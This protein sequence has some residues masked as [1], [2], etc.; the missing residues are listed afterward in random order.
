MR[1]RSQGMVNLSQE[2]SLH[3]IEVEACTLYLSTV[4]ARGW[5]LNLLGESA[6]AGLLANLFKCCYDLNGERYVWWTWDK[7][8][9]S[10]MLH[11][12]KRL[13]GVASCHALFS[14]WLSRKNF[15]TINSIRR[16]LPMLE[17]HQGYV[18]K[19]LASTLDGFHETL[20][21]ISNPFLSGAVVASLSFVSLPVLVCFIRNRSYKLFMLMGLVQ[22]L[23][24]SRTGVKKLDN[25]GLVRALIVY[26]AVQICC[27]IIGNAKQ[28]FST[29]K[30]EPFSPANP[31]NARYEIVGAKQ[32]A[33][34]H[35]LL[36]YQEALVQLQSFIERNTDNLEEVKK[37]NTEAIELSLKAMERLESSIR[38]HPST[39]RR[40]VYEQVVT[41]TEERVDLLNEQ[42]KTK[43]RHA[44]TVTEHL[45]AKEQSICKNIAGLERSIRELE[46]DPSGKP[47]VAAHPFGP[48]RSWY[49][50]KGSLDTPLAEKI[51]V[52]GVALVGIC[53]FAK[54]MI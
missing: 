50:V 44:K 14:G 34:E 21:N 38:E 47:V 18:L 5:G 45:K 49:T 28:H 37:T 11:L 29:S 33:L 32:V 7:R 19:T 35:K 39:G 54:S 31:T 20:S 22:A 23:R 42:I 27:S 1:H 43:Q 16:H 36:K 12:W 8:E 53:A 52:C 48:N 15:S 17:A 10:H 24:S 46:Y 40:E 30:H 2:H 51:T 13:A 9:N 25:I 41:S 26:F 6:S 4:A 3:S